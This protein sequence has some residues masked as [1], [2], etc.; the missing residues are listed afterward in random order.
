MEMALVARLDHCQDNAPASVQAAED[1]SLPWKARS[2]SVAMAFLQH[3]FALKL[4]RHAAHFA[5]QLTRAIAT[6]RDL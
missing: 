5:S 1:D 6:L 3:D 4:G 2:G